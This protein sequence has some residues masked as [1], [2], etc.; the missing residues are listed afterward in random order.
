LFDF[1][2]SQRKKFGKIYVRFGTPVSLRAALGAP[3]DGPQGLVKAND[4]EKVAF[5]VCWRINQV[6]PITA[7]SLLSLVLLATRGR[8][9]TLDEMKSATDSLLD[10]ARAR[11]LPLA[12]SAERLSDRDGLDKVLASMASNRTVEIY[13]GGLETVYRVATGNEHSAAFY[14]NTT[15]HFFVNAAITEAALIHAAEHDR[16]RLVAF[17]DEAYRL[18]DLFKFDFFFE[19]KEDFRKTVA[20]ELTERL[21]GWEG[22]LA[23]GAD[24]LDLLRELQPL[25]AFAVLRPFVESYE[26]VAQA[27]LERP[28]G[29]AIDEKP[30]LRACLGLGRQLVRQ[31]VIRNPEAISEIL[32]ATGLQLVTHLGLT[33]DAPDV[34]DQRRAFAARLADLRRRIALTEMLAKDS[35]ERRSVTRVGS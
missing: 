18:R 29:V 33:R 22:R 26:V 23:D 17:W 14:R 10:L 28:R 19:P 5:E 3:I 25:L 21:P 32:F 6:T 15:I 30:F 12:S 27:L 8:S 11:R 31:G 34:V 7:S 35:V 1:Y 4:L 24:P 2:R 9:V 16:D 20:T 13:E